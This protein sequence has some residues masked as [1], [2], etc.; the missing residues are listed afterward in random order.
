MKNIQSAVHRGSKG[1]LIVEDSSFLSFILQVAV[2]EHLKIEPVMCT[3]LREAEEVLE[4]NAHTFFAALLDLHL[5]DAPNGEV[6]DLVVGYEIPS[7]V[8]TATLSDKLRERMWSK[9]IVDYV[10]KENQENVVQVMETIKRLQKNMGMKVLVADDSFTCRKI[11]KNLLEVWNFTVLEAVDGQDA[12]AIL[13]QEPDVCMLITDYNMPR[14]NGV[15]LVKQIR[16]SH[17]KARLPIIGLSGVDNATTSAYFLK[18]GANDY[19]H[20]PFIT[21]ELYCRVRHNIE[22]AEHI[23]TIRDMAERDF[24]TGLYNR[25]YFF[26]MADK[27]LKQTRRDNRGLVIAMMDIDYFKKC[28]DQFGHDAGDEVIRFVGQSILSC[29]RESDL[30]ARFGGEEYCIACAGMDGEGAR[31]VFEKIRSSIEGAVINFD[32]HNI[33]VTVSIGVCPSLTGSLEEMITC[34]DKMLYD[35]KKQ[36]RNQVRVFA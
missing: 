25:R 15:D 17:S 20:K 10:L 18:A 3:G 31:K 5:P 34:A 29:V 33:K 9:K 19:L 35:A 7:V 23:K 36:G 21:E 26:A 14:L 11:V 12:L 22:I 28:N 27:M 13:K 6:V 16:R 4:T 8:F 24:L 1:V 2:R 32:N 30:V